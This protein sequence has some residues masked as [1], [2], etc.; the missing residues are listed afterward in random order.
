MSIPVCCHY[1]S[2]RRHSI[3]RHQSDHTD[4]N[5]I[6]LILS[7][8][9]TCLLEL[10]HLLRQMI[11]TTGITFEIVQHLHRM[12]VVRLHRHITMVAEAVAVVPLET[13]TA[14]RD[15]AI[16]ILITPAHHCA[17]GSL[18]L[19]LCFQGFSCWDS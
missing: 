16:D 3:A 2:D 6:T 9:G 13:T 10:R 7:R 4:I 15:I 19:P 5:V 8:R 17:L 1:F 11:I 18:S 12:A 14:A